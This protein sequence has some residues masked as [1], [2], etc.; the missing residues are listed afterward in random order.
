M[1]N[2]SFY[3]AKL[4]TVL[5]RWT[6]KRNANQ[7]SYWG[8]EI[9]ARESSS[10]RYV[11]KYWPHTRVWSKT[12]SVFASLAGNTKEV[13]L[14]IRSI[15]VDIFK[16]YVK[17]TSFLSADVSCPVR[18]K[19]HRLNFQSLVC[20]RSI[21]G[22]NQ[23]SRPISFGTLSILHRLSFGR[24]RPRRHRNCQDRLYKHH[25]LAFQ[26]CRVQRSS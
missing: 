18:A 17:S 10:E 5:Y 23:P 11:R 6:N 21:R 13:V 20:S 19:T 3:L 1:T 12:Q 15:S 4:S 26:L 2:I 24:K 8:M 22:K 9:V 16:V 25:W 14:G 7:V